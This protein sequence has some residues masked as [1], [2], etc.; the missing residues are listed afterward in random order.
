MM[1]EVNALSDAPSPTNLA[2]PLVNEP[3]DE[4][5][6]YCGDGDPVPA[7]QYWVCPTCDAEW[8]VCDRDPQP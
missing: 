7:D 1:K 3:L 5:C 6:P 8:N 4:P 2:E